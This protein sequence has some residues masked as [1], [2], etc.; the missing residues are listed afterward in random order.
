MSLS[1]K[2]YKACMY[3][4]RIYTFLRDVSFI[5]WNWI[6]WPKRICI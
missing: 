4:G 2:H 5:E 6:F 1:N 3:D